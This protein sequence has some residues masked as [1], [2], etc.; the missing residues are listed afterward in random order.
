MGHLFEPSEADHWRWIGQAA[1]LGDFGYFFDSFSEQVRVFESDRSNAPVVFAIGHVLNQRADF[2]KGEIFGY[3]GWHGREAK[4]AVDFYRA[5]EQAARKAVLA[6]SHVGF[7]LGVV[8]DIRVL[9][10]KLVWEARRE[11]NYVVQ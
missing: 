8:K 5:Q 4:I 1:L 7:L 10:A 6:W 2:D 3:A 11:A 9:I